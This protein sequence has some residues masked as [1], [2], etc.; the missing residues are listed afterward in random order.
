M[1][2]GSRQPRQERTHYAEAPQASV[3]SEEVGEKPAEPARI[4]AA[5]AGQAA[6]RRPDDSEA[7]RLAA[8]VAGRPDGSEG[9]AKGDSVRREGHGEERAGVEEAQG[10]R[11]TVRTGTARRYSG[12]RRPE[13]PFSEAVACAAGR[14]ERNYRDEG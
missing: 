5:R 14:C 9:R 1:R 7:E 2:A 3:D 12:S 4:S 13:L 8:R 10:P 11:A 6:A